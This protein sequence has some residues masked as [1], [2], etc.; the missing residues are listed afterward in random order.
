MDSP[1]ADESMLA[2]D[3]HWDDGSGQGEHNASAAGYAV[4]S[5]GGI[6]T[7]YLSEYISFTSDKGG[8]KC[9][10]LSLFVCRFV[11]K[12]TQKRVHGFG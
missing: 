10:C 2:W 9:F 6:I 3:R 11:S 1:R 5:S 12:I 7:V 8:G 4:C